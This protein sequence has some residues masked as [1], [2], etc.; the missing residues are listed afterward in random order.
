MERL[1]AESPEGRLT[2]QRRERCWLFGLVRREV[3]IQKPDGRLI[4]RSC[5]GN[6]WIIAG[7]I[8]ANR[9]QEYEDEDQ[10]PPSPAP[11]AGGS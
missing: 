4:W 3:Q 5:R 11:R 8:A 9:A 6:E 1:E 7:T 2:G 10:D